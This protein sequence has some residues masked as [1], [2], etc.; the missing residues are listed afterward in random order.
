MNERSDFSAQSSS[1][2]GDLSGFSTF[3]TDEQSGFS[4][5]PSSSMDDLSGLAEPTISV[6]EEDVV[7]IIDETEDAQDQNNPSSF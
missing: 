5:Q 7:I 1:S 2:M 3:E 4:A 6:Y